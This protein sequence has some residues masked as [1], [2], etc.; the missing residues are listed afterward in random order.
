M[1][2]FI[3]VLTYEGSEQ[4]INTAFKNPAVPM[5][6]SR[7][8]Y[9]GQ[10]TSVVVMAQSVPCTTCGLPTDNLTLICEKCTDHTRFLAETTNPEDKI[11]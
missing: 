2:K 8:S 7:P 11:L 4:F 9:N 6:G 1:P 10:I 5:N 3:R